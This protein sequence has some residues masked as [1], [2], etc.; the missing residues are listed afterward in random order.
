MR[1][2]SSITPVYGQVCLL[3]QHQGKEE[4]FA[5]PSSPTSA[6]I[7]QNHPYIAPSRHDSLNQCGFIVAPASQTVGQH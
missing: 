4:R 3:Y 5:R 7:K 6:E 2:L 1:P